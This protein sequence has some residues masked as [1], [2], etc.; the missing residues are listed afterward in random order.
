V[1]PHHRTQP[2]RTSKCVVAVRSRRLQRAAL[3]TTSLAMGRA[4]LRVAV[5]WSAVAVLLGARSTG[6]G[7]AGPSSG[8]RVISHTISLLTPSGELALQLAA[9]IAAD[10]SLSEAVSALDDGKH[11]TLAA[12]GGPRVA[13]SG[14]TGAQIPGEVR[15]TA[16]TPGGTAAAPSLSATGTL[17]IKGRSAIPGGNATVE[18]HTDCEC[19]NRQLLPLSFLV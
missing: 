1:R 10:G 14:P 12:Y 8:S 15:W 17:V 11:T 9:T 2:Q 3:R 7:T 4:V 18:T 5:L 13:L 6:A 19:D 16:L